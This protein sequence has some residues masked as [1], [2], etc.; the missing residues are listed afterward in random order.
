MRSHD[1]TGY[2]PQAILKYKVLSDLMLY[3]SYARGFRSGGFNQTGVAQAAA[4]AGFVGVG[5]LFKAEHDENWEA[6]FKSR[7]FDN[8]LTLN[9]S[10]YTNLSKNGY[11]FVFL[12]SNST[13]NLGNIPEVRY[14][15]FDVD[16]TARITDDIEVDA[17]FGYTDSSVKK[18]YHD[19][20]PQYDFRIGEQAP[21]VSKYTFNV[22]GQYKP[23]LTNTLNGLIRVDYELIGPTYFWESDPNVVTAGAPPVFSRDPVG[24]IDARV[25]IEGRDWSLMFWGKNLNN[26]IYNAEYSPGGFV[27]KAL[28]RRWG[29]DLS[30]KF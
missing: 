3:V 21:L 11:F 7:L 28:P 8:R 27:F 24:L 30:R 5:D 25:G 29:V 18:Y 17:G 23:R 12:A 20:A 2:Q 14:T 4:A 1:F 15:G 9:G 19:I 6:G 16:A 10:A 26:R 22:G 13:Q